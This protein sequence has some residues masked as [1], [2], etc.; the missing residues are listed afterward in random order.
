MRCMYYLL[1]VYICMIMSFEHVWK[2]T[3]CEKTLGVSLGVG[4]R[5]V[6]SWTVLT[7]TKTVEYLDFWLCLRYLLSLLCFCYF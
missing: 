1:Y 3:Y 5:G 4:F 2:D 7:N 6:D